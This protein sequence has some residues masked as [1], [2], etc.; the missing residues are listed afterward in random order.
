MPR[1]HSSSYLNNDA[2]ASVL[3]IQST[4]EEIHKSLM[5]NRWGEKNSI[6]KMEKSLFGNCLKFPDSKFQPVKGVKGGAL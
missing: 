3:S 4:R 6:K 5:E 2:F 1:S